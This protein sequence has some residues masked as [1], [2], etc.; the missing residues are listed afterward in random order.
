MIEFG[1][2]ARAL[3]PL[4]AGTC[5]LNHGSFGATPRVVLDAAE[6]WRLRME[7]NPDHFLREVLPQELRHAAAR[8][9]AYIHAHAQDVVFVENATA[10]INSVLRPLEFQPSAEIVA[11]SQ[12]HGAERQAIR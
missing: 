3:F 2:P 8:L 9:A 5:F 11:T 7:A 10:G 1:A 6:R 4:E 12:C